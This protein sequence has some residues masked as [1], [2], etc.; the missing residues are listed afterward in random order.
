[1][2]A[3]KLIK[4]NNAYNKLVNNTNKTTG[5]IIRHYRRKQSL[6]LSEAANNVASTSYLSKV[7]NN[8]LIPSQ[9][10]LLK[11]AKNLNIPLEEFE[12]EKK[13]AKYINE[14]LMK[15]YVPT[16]I[17]NEFKNRNDAEAKLIKFLYKVLNKED[18]SKAK[19]ISTDLLNYYNHFNEDQVSMFLYG[20]LK[21]NFINERYF[22]VI[23]I[24]K[25]IKI[26]YNNP[27][28]RIKSSEIVLKAQCKLGLY[29]EAYKKY[30]FLISKS[31]LYKSY[32]NLNKL[33]HSIIYEEA[34]IFD[35]K[36]KIN[37]YEHYKNNLNLDLIYFNQYFYYK[38]NYKEAFK[39]I[40]NIKNDK[41]YYY[42][43][44]LITLDKLNETDKLIKSLNYEDIPYFKPSYKVIIKYFKE[45]SSSK[46]LSDELL[47]ELKYLN[48]ITD[49]YYI[50][51]YVY[52]ELIKYYESRHKYKSSSNVLKKIIELNEKKASIMLCHN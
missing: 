35:I 43:L 36:D 5:S 1:M 16:N 47:F 12:Y 22:E 17:L 30:N 34:K 24:Y 2:D 48:I 28:I 38:K 45:K 18:Y 51:K 9:E 27:I 10:K 13:D 11:L 6:T 49:D 39:Y 37:E 20:C 29:N 52:N 46:E 4:L 14:I 8:Q 26:L 15:E 19:I 41:D 3:L 40:D 23:N 32:S 21:L 7:E 31:Y 42:L 25:G 33:K 44:Y 50:L